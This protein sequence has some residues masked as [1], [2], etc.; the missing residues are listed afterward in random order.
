MDL[1]DRVVSN[2]EDLAVVSVVNNSL[3]PQHTELHLNPKV[4]PADTVRAVH[5]FHSAVADSVN[6]KAADLEVVTA[7]VDLVDN[8]KVDKVDN[9]DKEVKAVR[10]DKE[11]I[12]KVVSVDNRAVLED[13]KAGKVDK[14]DKVD[15][16]DRVVTARAVATAILQAVLAALREQSSNNM[17]LTEDINTNLL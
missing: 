11:V 7:K 1:V 9:Q 12:A 5:P 15:R 6:N 2:K 17:P 8:N 4:V 10:E 14:V 16:E 3:H 13:S